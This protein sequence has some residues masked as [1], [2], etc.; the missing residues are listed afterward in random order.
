MPTLTKWQLRF[1]DQHYKHSVPEQP[2]PV[3]GLNEMVH[4]GN[5]RVGEKLHRDLAV[6]AMRHQQS[7][8]EFIKTT[9]HEKMYG[10]ATEK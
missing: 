9:L 10:Y 8:N 5:V 2:F 3:L 6:E 1:F 4:R 7:L